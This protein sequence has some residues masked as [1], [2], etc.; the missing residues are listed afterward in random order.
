MGGGGPPP[1]VPGL[2]SPATPPPQELMQALMRRPEQVN[3]L[4]KQAVVLLRQVADLDPRQEPRISAA[5]KII[6]GPTK[7]GAEP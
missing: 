3:Q 6:S 7:P 4:M 1:T 5:L 2:T